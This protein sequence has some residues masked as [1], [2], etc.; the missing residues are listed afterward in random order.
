MQTESPAQDSA[1]PPLDQLLA[2]FARNL[3]I[4]DGGVGSQGAAAGQAAGG[5]GGGGRARAGTSRCWR[6]ASRCRPAGARQPAAAGA[7][8][9]RGSPGLSGS[10]TGACCVG[11]AAH[12]GRASLTPQLAT[13]F[14]R[15][16]RQASLPHGPVRPGV[17]PCRCQC[18]LYMLGRQ[19]RCSD[20]LCPCRCSQA[21][22]DAEAYRKLIR[23]NASGAGAAGM[24]S[25]PG[26]LLSNNKAHKLACSL[27]GWDAL[28][29]AG[30]CVCTCVCV[31]PAE[32]CLLPFLRINRPPDL[33][34][35]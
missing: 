24:D 22:T 25:F 8:A 10:S 29:W 18:V 31:C 11:R 14:R 17:G 32:P 34:W 15:R 4:F 33:G 23:K 21:S 16:R 3:R 7:G 5:G 28:G 6:A 9:A 12:S 35:G 2:D 27:V 30:L 1:A 26:V 13:Q 20:L 19:A